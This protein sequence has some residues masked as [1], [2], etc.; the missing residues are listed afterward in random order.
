MAISRKRP[1]DMSGRDVVG[2]DA[3]GIPKGTDTAN[4]SD[5]TLEGIKL[6]TSKFG[7]DLFMGGQRVTLLPNV[8]EVVPV[9]TLAPNETYGIAANKTVPIKMSMDST[10]A[11]LE[12]PMAPITGDFITFYD[13]NGSFNSKTGVIIEAIKLDG[14]VRDISFKDKNG[15][16]SLKYLGGDSGWTVLSVD[17]NVPASTALVQNTVTTDTNFADKEGLYTVTV[18]S[19]TTVYPAISRESVK[20]GDEVVVVYDTGDPLLEATITH[21]PSAKFY[22]IPRNIIFRRIVI[23]YRIFPYGVYVLRY[24]VVAKDRTTVEFETQVLLPVVNDNVTTSN[25]EFNRVNL[26]ELDY[27][28]GESFGFLDVI[29][30]LTRI[31]DPGLNIYAEDFIDMGGTQGPNEQAVTK[32][33]WQHSVVGEFETCYYVTGNGNGAP[34]TIINFNR[35]VVKIADSDVINYVIPRISKHTTVEVITDDCNLSIVGTEEQWSHGDRI[36]IHNLEDKVSSLSITTI[37]LGTLTFT[38][39]DGD[40]HSILTMTGPG[41]SEL[42]FNSTTL[43]FELVYQVAI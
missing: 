3:L 23:H 37:D 18:T 40:I 19:G 22:G 8:S 43:Q 14:V 9:I 1:M 32:A 35:P 11:K 6:N 42:R 28:K 2:S 20:V 15:F 33:K 36:K 10:T 7:L 31:D 21:L 27:M 29:G 17:S 39:E 25:A 26:S 5:L 4:A 38:D 12:I 13:E 16:Y 41:V 30:S 34:K 24:Q